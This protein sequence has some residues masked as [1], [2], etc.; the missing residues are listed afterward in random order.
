MYYPGV[1]WGAGLRNGAPRLDGDFPAHANSGT[2]PDLFNK[3]V[4]LDREEP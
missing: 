4:N 2:M 3:T 1:W